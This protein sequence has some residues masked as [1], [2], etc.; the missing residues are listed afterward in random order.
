MIVQFFKNMKLKKTTIGLFFRE[1]ADMYQLGLINNIFRSATEK[2][3]NVI[4]FSGGISG[5]SSG[6]DKTLLFNMAGER[7]IDGLIVISSAIFN[8]HNAAEIS[9]FFSRYDPVPAVSIGLD[10]PGH[11][12]VIVDSQTGFRRLLDHMFK[13]HSSIH[14]LFIK[15]PRGHL[16]A[17]QRYEIFIETAERYRLS[18]KDIK[19]LEGDFSIQSGKALIS[20]YLNEHTLSDI[21]CIIA[22]NDNMALGAMQVL[23][24]HSLK[25]PE[26]IAV[27]G[28]D[29][30]IESTYVLPNLTTVDQ[31]VRSIAEIAVQ[32]VLSLL[33]GGKPER[34][35]IPTGFINRQ[36]C[37]CVHS[38]M[39]G[40]LAVRPGLSVKLGSA[41]GPRDRADLLEKILRNSSEA[42]IL[43]RRQEE[44][45]GFSIR[46]FLERLHSDAADDT[47]NSAYSY[48][49]SVFYHNLSS[50]EILFDANSLIMEIRHTLSEMNISPGSK[51]SYLSR[52]GAIEL[53]SVNC[54]R[55]TL[56][57]QKIDNE[58]KF[59]AIQKSISL[60]TDSTNI[61]QLMS[62]TGKIAGELAFSRCYVAL[63]DSSSSRF[64]SS[65]RLFLSYQKGKTNIPGKTGISFSTMDL[66]PHGSIDP[67][68]HFLLVAKPLVFQNEPLGFIMFEMNAREDIPYMDSISI[69]LSSALKSVMMMEKLHDREKHLKVAVENKT[70]QLLRLNEQLQND[71]NERKQL[72]R[73]ILQI[74]S[75]ERERIG[76]DIHDVLCQNLAGISMMLSA[77]ANAAQEDREELEEI[78]DTLNDTIVEARKMA[79]GYFNISLREDGLIPTLREYTEKISEMYGVNCTLSYDEDLEIPDAEISLHFYYLVQEAVR[80][81]ITHGAPDSIQVSLRREQK[82]IVLRIEDDGCGL[83]GNF[84][85]Q[86]G[87]GFHLMQYRANI[88][89]GKFSACRGSSGGTSVFCSLPLKSTVREA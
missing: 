32:Q 33:E 35:V 13:E 87:L 43:I 28:F 73:G 20:G 26:D 21:D 51:N 55:K 76:S 17:D 29:N 9:D 62:I 25:V 78:I 56:L 18:P 70:R 3:V 8:V 52:I 27:T 77:R 59:V 38:A 5:G 57:H 67:A 69:H 54:I 19:V 72:E 36:S 2:G 81:A 10:V 23:S 24:E 85:E 71:I 6:Q 1:L 14:P 88:I 83:P 63:F 34:I 65:S 84:M 58:R 7:N 31:P 11:S 47:G 89:G 30:N 60:L 41:G 22:S 48:F 46:E 74:S 61:Y 86:K 82:L 53:F 44:S 12:S 40:P 66:F 39:G 42:A 37:G 75:R 15:G 68:G 4:C 16:E 80:N 64:P 79:H 49:V 50:P 45:S